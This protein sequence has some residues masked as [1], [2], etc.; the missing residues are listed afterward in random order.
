MATIKLF[1]ILAIKKLILMLRLDKSNYFERIR[2]IS[3]LILCYLT[4]TRYYKTL[5]MELT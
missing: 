4:K 3:F 1:D 5:F 2:N